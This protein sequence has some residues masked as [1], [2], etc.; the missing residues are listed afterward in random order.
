M[1]ILLTLIEVTNATGFSATKI[2]RLILDG[3]FPKSVKIDGNTRWR[4]R[5]L[6]AWEESLCDEQVLVP[7]Q[8]VKRGRPR[9]AP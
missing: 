8:P 1:K 5:D 9:L 4:V 7:S 6:N 2:N 3:R